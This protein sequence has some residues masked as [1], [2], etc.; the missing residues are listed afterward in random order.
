MKTIC[1]LIMVIGVS[2]AAQ[3]QPVKYVVKLKDKGGSGYSLSNP[4]A[5]LSA[6]SIA[7]RSRQH[8]ALDSSDLPV[9][10]SYVANLQGIAGVG[11]ISTSRWFNEVFVE[12]AD[13][14]LIN[15]IRSMPF[16]QNYRR[17]SFTP[18]PP[19]GIQAIQSTSDKSC[20]TAV[21]NTSAIGDS[22][23]YGMNFP[24]V[25][26]HE[27]EFLHNLGFRGEGITIAIL[28]AGF[29]QYNT[30][31]AL[32]S[33]RSGGQVV[34]IRDFV[35][36][37]NSVS[38]DDAHGA[39][40]LTI[41]SANRPGFMVGTAPKAGYLLYRTEYAPTETPSEEQNWIVAAEA[42]DSAGADMISSSLGYVDFDNPA[43]NHSYPDR[44]GNTA[45][46]TIA[47]DLAAKKGMIVTNSAGNAGNVPNDTKYVVCPADGDSVM[48]VGAVDK[49]GT[50][51]TFSSWGPGGSGKMKPNIASV[52]QAAVF[53]NAAG[54]PTTGNGTSYS[55]PNIA[56][57][58]ACLWQA[59]PDLTNMDIFNAVEQ[60]SNK[61]TDPDNRLGYGL[62]NFKKAFQIL[63][64][65]RTMI[66][67]DEG[68]DTWL[69]ASP[70]PFTT[71]FDVFLKAPRS[72]NIS[73]KMLDLSGRTLAVKRLQVTKN[74]SYYIPFAPPLVRTGMYVV[75]YFD[76]ENRRTIKLVRE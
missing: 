36:N 53:A 23:F 44:N 28:D 32:D 2:V 15:T 58:I 68:R 57:L 75:V 69:G 12:L 1:L 62:P 25:H 19:R 43:F 59:F 8:I 20:N 22:S 45:K 52:G 42:A 24:Q 35:D 41:L 27:G 55:N 9:N 63:S 14:S 13:S 46:I 73:L 30:N 47:A 31:P 48:T 3:A 18:R 37:D 40:C 38:E 6:K 21:P 4:S 65:K 29:Y 71:H 54:E 67:H 61:F 74:T 33:M 11:V 64:A 26:I 51:A 49:N 34:A 76:G 17:L 56:G 50:L 16:V 39:N 7:R 72:G 5:W 70:V 66:A 60:S 10:P